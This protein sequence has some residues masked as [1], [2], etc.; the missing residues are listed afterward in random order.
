MKR[1]LISLSLALSA[2]LASAAT[3]VPVQL[4]NPTGST[5]GQVVYSNGPS[6]APSWSSISSGSL[7]AQAANSVIANATGASASPTAIVVPS[8]STTTSALNWTSGTGFTCGGSGFASLAGSSFVGGV[9]LSYT[10]PALLVNDTSAT[11]KAFVAFQKNGTTEWDFSNTSSSNLFALDRYVSGTYTDSP[12]SVSA[13]TG[14]VTMTDGVT[15]TPIS[16]STGSFTT[17]RASS[18]IT[19]AYPAGIIGNATGSG[20][21]AG[22]VGE[23]PTPTNLSAVS[24]TSGTFVNCA[25]IALTAGDWE[26]HG[27]VLFS[28]AASTVVT[29]VSAGVSSTSATSGGPGTNT[30]I[31]GTL[32]TGLGQAIPAPTTRVIT[33]TPITV[34]IVASAT[35][36]TSTMTCAGYAYARRF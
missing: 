12:F 29:A 28:P 27:Q 2:A 5:T 7:G 34:Y 26:V 8:C 30:L 23:V 25:S 15:G 10:N 18:A 16:G 13:S 1:I 33:S 32:G 24:M 22:S 20:V 17:L 31:S 4:I 6:S 35:F 9:S 14:A 3:T 21:T 19:P 36:S 11:N